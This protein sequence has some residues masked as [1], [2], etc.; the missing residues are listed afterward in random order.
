M[1]SDLPSS[2]SPQ[3]PPHNPPATSRTTLPP[4]PT[5]S[6]AG[7]TPSRTPPVHDDQQAELIGVGIGIGI[8]LLLVV[9]VGAAGYGLY[10]LF[11]PL[12]ATEVCK[13]LDGV[14]TAAEAKQYV[15]PRMYPLV[16][17]VHR[18]KSPTDPNDTFEW[19]QEADGPAPNTKL[20]GFSGSWFIPE[21][22]RRVRV[23]GHC[24]VVKSDGW[25]VD[26]MVF[27]GVEGVSLP[28]PVS[29][30]DEHRASLAQPKTPPRTTL[31]GAKN[32]TSSS[33]LYVPPTVPQTPAW[34]KNRVG[35]VIASIR[36]TIGWAG[37]VVIVIV[38]IVGAAVRESLQ[39]KAPRS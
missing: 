38:F 32:R 13:K 5:K 36:D 22:G 7:S 39:K 35:K 17:E 30:V 18:T 24:K 23:E 4:L 27:T 1:S 33:G 31:P 9:I 6:P 25:K 20:V 37:I 19:T 12:T 14:K 29:L 26:D 10:E 2:G 15:T 3:A 28:G 16:D 21:E 11:R 8:V 34:E